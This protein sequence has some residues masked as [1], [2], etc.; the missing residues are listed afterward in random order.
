MKMSNNQFGRLQL[1]VQ[2]IFSAKW[3][4]TQGN[5]EKAIDALIEILNLWDYSELN[6][7]V[8]D[9]KSIYNAGAAVDIKCSI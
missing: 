6:V 4:E 7:L 5:E 9:L 8:G 2:Q 3:H 1:T